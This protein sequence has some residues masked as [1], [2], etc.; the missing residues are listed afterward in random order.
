M[1]LA[2]SIRNRLLALALAPLLGV[3]PLLGLILL[4]WGHAAI[5]RLLIGK[6]RSDLAVAQGYFERVL[7]EVGGGTQAVA[8]SHRLQVALADGPQAV[9]ALLDRVRRE[10]GLDFLRWLPPGAAGAGG[11]SA[12]VAVLAPAELEALAPGLAA[13]SRA[14]L[15]AT[16]GAAPTERT[17]EDRGLVLV[18]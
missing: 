13:R 18:A 2:G 1:R 6:I 10:R 4:L 7:T 11:E 3:L 12:S 14:P 16:E 9:A 15:V 17:V 8:E 5:D